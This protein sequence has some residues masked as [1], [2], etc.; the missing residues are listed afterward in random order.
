MDKFSRIVPMRFR[1]DEAYLRGLAVSFSNFAYEQDCRNFLNNM[2]QFSSR[3]HPEEPPYRRLNTVLTALAPT[4]AHP[5]IL[6]WNAD[7]ER[8]SANVSGRHRC[9]TPPQTRANER[10][11][12]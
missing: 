5:F 12:L 9:G 3:D 8:S 11:D 10:P 6:R 7:T 2:K 1:I 4:L